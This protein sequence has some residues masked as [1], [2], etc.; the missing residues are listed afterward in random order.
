M[1]VGKDALRVIDLNR[2]ALIASAWLTQVTAT[3]AENRTYAYRA[4]MWTTPVLVVGVADLQPLTI[5]CP[6]SPDPAWPRTSYSA[7]GIK[8]NVSRFSWRGQV[9]QGSNRIIWSPARIG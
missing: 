1:D 6:D 8:G 4:G 5:G 3:P 9:Y 2:N 7:G